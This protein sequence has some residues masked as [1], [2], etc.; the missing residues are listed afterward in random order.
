VALPEFPAPSALRFQ[1]RFQSRKILFLRRLEPPRGAL[2]FLEVCRKLLDS[3]FEFCAEMCGWGSQRDLVS[4]KILEHGLSGHVSLSEVSLDEVASVID[5]AAVSVV[6][7][8][9]SEGSSL[10]A[11]ESIA[12]GV[13]VVSTDTGGLGNVV[14]PGFNGYTAPA[15]PDSLAGQL[16]HLLSDWA[17]YLELARNAASMRNA[18]SLSRWT[19]TLDDA[20][21]DSGLLPADLSSRI[22]EAVVSPLVFDEQTIQLVR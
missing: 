7:S 8:L 3:G 16:R 1:E 11:I 22:S 17:T 6:P 10:S 15:N 14:V 12:M 4:A 2:L 13:P 20:L 18:F 19:R 9:W 5:R 21:M